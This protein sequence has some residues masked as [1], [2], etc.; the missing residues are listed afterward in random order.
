MKNVYMC[1]P[2]N[3]SNNDIGMEMLSKAPITLPD[4]SIPILLFVS[5]LNPT[6]KLTSLIS[7][8]F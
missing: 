7:I 5:Y 4:L 2:I 1:G 3:K 6:K 8:F